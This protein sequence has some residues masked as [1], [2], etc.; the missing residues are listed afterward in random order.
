MAFLKALLC[1]IK[2]K[3]M[4]PKLIPGFCSMKQLGGQNDVQVFLLLRE[5]N[6]SPLQGYSSIE[7]TGT[8]LYTWFERVIVRVKYL[9]QDHNAKSPARAQTRA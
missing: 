4:R 1:I 5:W 2:V 6:A 3:V 8:H 7:S 9:A